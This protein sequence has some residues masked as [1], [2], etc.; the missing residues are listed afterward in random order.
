[1]MM[2]VTGIILS[3]GKSK[4]MGQDKGLIPIQGKPMI[5][6]VIDHISPVC[7]TILISANQKVYETFGFPVI[8]DTLFKAGPVAGILSCLS[9]STTE[10]NLVISCDLPFASTRLISYLV[11]Q[12]KGF[13]ITLPVI[14]GFLQPLCAVYSK[15]VLEG[16]LKEVSAGEYSLQRIVR[17][18]NLNIVEENQIQDL[19]LVYELRNMNAPDDL[20]D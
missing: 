9:Q 11:D 15:S 13:D 17:T 7:S 5:Q 16:I 12:S 2:H 14:E 8:P 3:G 20:A 10:K 4:R 19:D 6:H 1:M 18:F